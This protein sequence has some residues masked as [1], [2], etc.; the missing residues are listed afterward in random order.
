MNPRE[1]HLANPFILPSWRSDRVHKML[2]AMPPE[3]CRRYDDEW[4]QGYK[5]FLSLWRRSESARTDLLYENPGLFYAHALHDGP[6]PDTDLRLILEAR[7][8][9]GVSHDEIANSLKTIKS[10][11]EWYE[12]LFFEVSPYLSH[13]DWILRHVLLP[14]FERSVM[15]SMVIDDSRPTD[16]RPVTP[17]MRPY[18]DS[19]L[20]FFAYYGGPLICDVMLSGFRRDQ[21]VLNYSDVEGYLDQQFS[22]QI[23]R[24]STQAAGLFEVNKYN[25][26]QLFSVHA[27]L[28]DIQQRAREGQ[29]TLTEV[30]SAM[31]S[32]M[33]E[34][35]FT[36][37][38]AA[39][40][41]YAVIPSG[42]CDDTAAEMSDDESISINHG[43]APKQLEEIAVISSASRKPLDPARKRKKKS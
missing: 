10:T 40:K 2:A 31:G 1:I 17:I 3:R 20:K 19:S 13:Y 32:M 18:L 27:Q 33:E 39:R 34:I 11:V 22:L 38:N 37:G 24:R 14:A 23:R 7:L 5:R 36:T 29:G 8:L 16:V 12:K 25:V 41:V 35:M 28:M 6:H 15:T 21:R 43:H 4:I 30:S 42:Q 26:I 9:S